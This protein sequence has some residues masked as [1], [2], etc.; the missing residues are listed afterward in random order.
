MKNFLETLKEELYFEPEELEFGPGFPVSYFRGE[1]F[2]E[3]EYLREFSE[4]LEEM[5]FE[6]KITLEL[7][8]SIAASCGTYLTSVV[9]MKSKNPALILLS[10]LRYRLSDC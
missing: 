8:R 6:S 3:D 10:K 7:G 9:D 2:N 5:A 1:E 4:L